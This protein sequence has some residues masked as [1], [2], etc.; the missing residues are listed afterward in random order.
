M[1][2]KLAIRNFKS[3]DGVSFEFE[4]VNLFIGPNAS[5]K[6]S[7]LQAIGILPA[8]L[9]PSIT[10]YL[11]E[12]KGWD[13][14]DLPHKKNLRSTMSWTAEYHLRDTANSPPVVYTY[15][16]DLQP[17]KHLGIGRERLTMKNESG[18]PVVLIDRTGR[19]TKI[20]N[21]ETKTFRVESLYNLPS[22][23]MQGL[24]EADPS[25]KSIIRFRKYLGS[26][27]SFLLWNPADLK[28]PHQGLAERL[29]PSGERLPGFLAYLA[30]NEPAKA[31]E[32]LAMLQRFF[33]R[34]EGIQSTGKRTWGWHELAITERIGDKLIEYPADH[35]S[36]GFLRMLAVLSFKYSPDPPR[37]ITLE[38]P[39]NGI[40]PHLISQVISHLRSL[41]ERK[42]PG[43]MQVFMTSHSPYV[44]SE[45]GSSPECV[46]IFEKGKND[47]VPR[48]IPLRGRADVLKAAEA[49]N[50]SLGD[51]WYS[52]VLGGGAK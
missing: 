34:V 42:E 37:I 38:E 19:D 31:G 13:Y 21:E 23:V 4:N 22:S 24:K 44:L 29:G 20:L 43:K 33:P 16:V 45:F 32:L 26:F 46:H 5:G 11:K 30:K 41:A 35:A 10:E 28:K 49:L 47:S 50:R 40:H 51:L 36:D 9:R 48:I 2:K 27:Q 17:R 6:S 18:E 14:R 12:E 3:L 8:M 52:N 15:E 39:E 25:V 7:V 1:L